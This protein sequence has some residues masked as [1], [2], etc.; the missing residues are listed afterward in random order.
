M[1]IF[2]VIME[3][4]AAVIIQEHNRQIQILRQKDEK[5]F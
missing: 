1:G 2:M 5:L 4:A 3:A